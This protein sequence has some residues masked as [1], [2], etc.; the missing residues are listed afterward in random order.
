MVAFA[1]S[2][3]NAYRAEGPTQ[4]WTAIETLTYHGINARY[5]LP[6]GVVSD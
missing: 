1:I 5:T 2:V 3:T 4:T 6:M